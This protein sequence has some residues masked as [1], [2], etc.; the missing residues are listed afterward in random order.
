MVLSTSTSIC[1]CFDPRNPAEVWKGEDSSKW[2]SSF[3]R[4]R[5]G[6]TVACR[7]LRA[8]SGEGAGRNPA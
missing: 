5:G 6:E 1:L 3:H 8:G 4:H 2:R 7:A